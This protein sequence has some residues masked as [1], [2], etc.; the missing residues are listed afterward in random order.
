M[1]DLVKKD[2][3]AIAEA[4]YEFTLTLPDGTETDAKVKVRGSSAPA[5]RAHAKRVYNEMQM[6]IQAARKRGKEPEEIS[7]EEAEQ[8]AAKNASVRVIGWS[9]VGENGKEIEFTTAEAERLF[10]KYP[11]FREQV[12]EESEDLH[13]FRFD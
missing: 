4:G 6:R 8:M 13:N 12:M 9:G 5:V 3:A 11:F 7:I 10:A 2:P 1:L